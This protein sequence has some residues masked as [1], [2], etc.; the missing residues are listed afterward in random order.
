MLTFF[1]CLLILAYRAVGGT[2]QAVD[3][4]MSNRFYEI[5][6]KERPVECALCSVKDGLHAMNP[7]FDDLD[8]KQVLAFTVDFCMET[9]VIYE[10]S[11][12]KQV[13]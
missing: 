9:Q 13:P 8:Q 7:L 2:Y 10:F 5:E 4:H 11:I 12:Q 6:Q 3:T 1:D